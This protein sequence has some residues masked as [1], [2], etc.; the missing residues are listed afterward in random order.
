MS[1]HLDVLQ[2]LRI[3]RTERLYKDAIINKA[4]VW[5]QLGA[6]KWLQQNIAIDD[7]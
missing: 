3:H 6:V 5:N 2:W 1:G 4:I 7:I